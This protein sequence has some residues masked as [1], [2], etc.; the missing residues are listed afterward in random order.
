MDRM[1]VTVAV[2]VNVAR[3]EVLELRVLCPGDNRNAWAVWIEPH[4]LR[5]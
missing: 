1:G 3:V 2:A 5:K 4:V